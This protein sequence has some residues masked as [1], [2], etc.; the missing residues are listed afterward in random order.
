MR[1]ALLSLMISAAPAAL[2]AA[3]QQIPATVTAVTLFPQGALVTRRVEVPGGEVLIPGLPDGTD[4]ASL[5]VHGEGTAVSAV[6]LIDGRVPPVDGGPGPAIAGA[7]AHVEALEAA[8]QVKVDAVA[9]TRAGAEAAR[10]RA[11]VLRGASTQGTSIDD[12]DR[13][14]RAV[15]DGVRAATEEALRIDAEARTA[16]AAL[17]PDREALDAARR[18]LA[19]LEHPGKESDALSVVTAGAG[20]LEITTF[21]AD[22][23]WTP[24]YDLS[25]DSAKGT[26][27]IGRFVS[28]RQAAGEDWAGVSLILLTARPT[29][30]AAPSELWPE[31]V[32]A[33]PP[34]PEAPA[35]MATMRKADMAFAEAAVVGNAAPEMIG[36]TLVYRYPAAVDIRDGVENLRLALDTISRPVT[37][38]AE[39]VPMLDA[40]AYRIVEGTNGPEPLLPGSAALIVDGAMVGAGYLP[41]VAGGDALRLGMGA[42]DGLTLTRV[43]PE[44][45][46]GGRGIVMRSN[47]REETA[48]ITVENLTARDWPVRVIDRAPYSEQDDLKVTFEADPAPTATGWSDKRGLLAWEF[49]LA[50]GAEKKIT[51]KTGLTWPSGQVLR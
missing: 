29:E 22:A 23:G 41:F 15:G 4:A 18:Q 32:Q 2:F 25:L 30:R 50:A 48:E 10:A 39:A 26:L 24:S 36:Q 34:E 12:L 46:S 5:R 21:V 8:L 42:I 47:A 35:P 43:V 11:D 3:P 17:K 16:D 27:D 49:D 33:G 14:A 9:V 37:E 44:A 1:T 45:S 38:R 20:T 19:A 6:T 51:L 13:L 7:R 28:V 40:T 31:L